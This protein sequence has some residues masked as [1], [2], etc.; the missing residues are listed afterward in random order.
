MTIK[1]KLKLSTSLDVNFDIIIHEN[2]F[3]SSNSLLVDQKCFGTKRRFIV[4]DEKIS[5]FYLN[6]IRNY[7]I[8][9][10]L[11]PF[12]YL[13]ECQE[14][15]KTTDTL[16]SI[17]NE[18]ENFGILR[19]SE[20]I[21]AIGGG[22]LLDIVGLAASIYRRGI[23][24]IK[25]PTTLIG[26]ID[27][28][29]GVKTGINYLNRRNRLGAYYPPI[30]VIIDKSFLKT[31]NKNFIS[32]GLGEI[33]KISI[34][35][36]YELFAMLEKY[37]KQILD[38][39]FQEFNDITNQILYLSIDEMRVELE[40]NLWEKNLERCVDFGHS[41]SPVIEM[42]SI[43]DDNVES[44]THGH[45]VGMDCIFSS[46]ISYKR[47]LLPKNDL[48]KIIKVAKSIEIP[49][50][51]SLFYDYVFVLEAL[52]DTMKHRDGNQYL[53]IPTKIG[54]YKFINDLNL[55]EIKVAIKF[56]EEINKK[57]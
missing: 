33:F 41:F 39:K 47:N 35:K 36:S 52:K 8:S 49:T 11:E 14:E 4:I 5:E 16:F 18:L 32:S 12:F 22:V 38:T 15:D 27:V 57:L 51:H 48:D 43:D 30:Q 9:N 19:R 56:L 3:T 46:I 37:G 54:H 44:L 26:L 45:A 2:L 25:I 23:P 50:K 28:S 1:K 21:I 29:V 40:S 55:N 24:Y 7:F 10:N 34:I 42:R 17:L 31:L 6:D 13:I 53:P 20:P